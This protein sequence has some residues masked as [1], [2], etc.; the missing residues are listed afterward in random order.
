MRLGIVLLVLGVAAALLILN[1][2]AGRVLGVESE[3]FAWLVIAVTLIVSIGSSLLL[4]FR[5]RFGTLLRG[6]A[7]WFLLFAGLVAAYGYRTEVQRVGMQAIAYLVPGTVVDGDQPGTAMAAR[8][9][10][11]HFRVRAAVN[12]AS[13]RFVVDTGA[14]SVVLT[15]RDAQTAGI[16]ISSLSYDARISTA[17]G[18][19]TA[20]PILLEDIAVGDITV[21]R[22]QALVAR[23]GQ[24]E[25]SLLGN[26]FLGRLATLTIEGDR[27]TL[28]R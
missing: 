9:R 6:A 25:T 13:I 22:V 4:R 16:D 26:S 15:E 18:M 21:R 11:G 12:G 3:D 24:L 1:H 17:N 28:K 10:D 19:S 5:G 23:P 8:S 2:D 20:A 27:L 14:T 7:I